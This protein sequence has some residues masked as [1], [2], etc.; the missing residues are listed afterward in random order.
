MQCFPNEQMVAAKIRVL[1]FLSVCLVA[2]GLAG[3]FTTMK[4]YSQRPVQCMPVE[5]YLKTDT[6]R[7]VNGV[8]GIFPFTAPEYAA[9]AANELR[10][11]YYRELV[12]DG[13]FRQVKLM[14]QVVG[15]DTEAVW[16]G[17]REGCDLVMLGSILYLLDGSGAA[18][19]RLQVGGRILDVRSEGPVWNIKQEAYSEPG[20]DVDL[21]W[22]TISGE[23]AQRYH[24][25]A[26]VLAEQFSQ[27]LM[28]PI[29]NKGKGF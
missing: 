4:A 10:S 19:T 14:Y 5:V 21:V 20:P 8:L 15:S 22:T 13:V 9:A 18:P 25:L 1:A 24:A 6:E 2:L 7:Y 12:Q 16:L 29:A 27:F 3:C 11:V 17:R 28:E 26:E 23:P